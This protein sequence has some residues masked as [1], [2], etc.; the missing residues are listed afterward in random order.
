V[1][2][3]ACNSVRACS[4]S[5][6]STRQC[7]KRIERAFGSTCSGSTWKKW[8]LHV[9]TPESLIHNYPG[10]KEK[11]WEA[12]IADLEALPG[13]FKVLGIN[14]YPP[15]FRTLALHVP[16]QSTRRCKQSYDYSA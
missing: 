13:E 3:A 6:H 2:C 11:A 16:L 1:L 5:R 4:A 10:G 12:F 15:Y 14:D 8:D 9:H 7:S